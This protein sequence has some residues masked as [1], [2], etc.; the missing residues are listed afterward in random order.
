MSFSQTNLTPMLRQ[1]FDFKAERPDVVLLMRVG[2]FY[3]A[4]GEDAETIARELEITLTG[5]EEKAG[6]GTH[7]DGGRPAS[8][9]GAVRRP[10]DRQGLQGRRLRSGRGPEAGEGAG[11]AAE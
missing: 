8:R 6:R 3:E 7:P 10:A 5:R 9:H 11:Q 2:D 1:Y 4:Y